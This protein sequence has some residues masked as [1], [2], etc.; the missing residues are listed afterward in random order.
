MRY[1]LRTISLAGVLCTLLSAG[2]HTPLT[3]Q[4]L[5]NGLV[6][7]PA[8]AGSRDALAANLTYR[9]QWVGFDGAPV[10]QMVSVHSPLGRRKLGAGLLVYNDR[11][12]VSQETGVF[13]NHA[14]RIRF[15]NG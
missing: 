11:I 6:I 14:Y 1:P 7:N 13:T 10:T 9:H 5:F 12:G 8:Y 2:Q 3:S 4:Y 15:R